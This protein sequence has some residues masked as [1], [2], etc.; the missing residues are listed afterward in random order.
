MLLSK[1][2]ISLIPLLL[3]LKLCCQAAFGHNYESTYRAGSSNHEPVEL[4]PDYDYTEINSVHNNVDQK[5]HNVKT[6]D[7]IWSSWHAHIAET[8]RSRFI[9]LIAKY[10]LKNNGIRTCKVN[11]V[12]TRDGRISDVQI[13]ESSGNEVFNRVAIDTI[14]SLNGDPILK[15]PPG[16]SNQFVRKSGLFVHHAFNTEKDVSK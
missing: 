2:L 13:T 15:F 11:Y 12:V 16:S 3:C 1:S 9:N 10:P 4:V 6:T 7:T 8:I 14:N 5:L